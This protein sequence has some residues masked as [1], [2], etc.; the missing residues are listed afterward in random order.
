M[1]SEEIFHPFAKMALQLSNEMKMLDQQLSMETD[2]F[3][4][5]VYTRQ[6]SGLMHL[7]DRC[8]RITGDFLPVGVSKKAKQYC[9]DNQLGDIFK[10]GWAEQ[11]VF[12]KKKNR[13]TCELKHEHKTPVSELI[14][15]LKAIDSVEEAIRLFESQEIVWIHKDED[16]LLPKSN[17]PDPDEAYRKAGIEVIKN[18]N[19]VGHLFM[20]EH[21]NDKTN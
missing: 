10:I 8:F 20:K 1:K 2:A 18:P 21:I 3:N 16:K 9:D 12:E 5:A 6:I 17:R 13:H 15:K 19:P 4:K 7:T 14:K 11:A